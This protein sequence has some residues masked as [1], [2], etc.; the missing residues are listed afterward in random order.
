MSSR[1]RPPQD[2]DADLFNDDDDEDEDAIETDAPPTRNPYASSNRWRHQ[3][4]SSFRK[5]A[6]AIQQRQSSTSSSTAKAREPGARGRVSDLADF[7]NSSRITPSEIEQ[8]KRGGSSAPGTPRFKPVM[9]AS[10][11]AKKMTASSR[12]GSALGEKEGPPPDQREIAVGP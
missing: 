4:S 11:D 7:L 10:A 8:Q 5:H 3:E 6:A 1:R 2:P 9:A 12:P